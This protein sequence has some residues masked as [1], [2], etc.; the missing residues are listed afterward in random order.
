MMIWPLMLWEGE[1]SMQSQQTQ[2]QGGAHQTKFDMLR[3]RTLALGHAAVVA[4]TPIRHQVISC[5]RGEQWACRA[6]QHN[7]TQQQHNTTQHNTTH[8][9][10]QDKT[11]TRQ[12]RQHS[13]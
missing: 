9:T 1:M 8:E 11:K 2:T 10:R 13:T 12:L 7:T 3:S 5:N 6:T 4:I